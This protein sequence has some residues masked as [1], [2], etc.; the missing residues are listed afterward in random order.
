MWYICHIIWML[1][2][3]MLT[4][5]K[6][7]SCWSNVSFPDHTENSP[8]IFFILIIKYYQLM[9]L[10]LL[11]HCLNIDRHTFVNSFHV[12]NSFLQY[13]ITFCWTYY[14]ILRWNDY[15]LNI[16]TFPFLNQ[17]RN[18]RTNSKNNKNDDRNNS[19]WYDFTEP[20]WNK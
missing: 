1:G 8:N 12:L 18:K 13:N 17:H 3:I 15:G 5:W 19:N 9:E 10:L 16:L 4:R 20:F 6:P 11:N 2:N 7:L 14:T